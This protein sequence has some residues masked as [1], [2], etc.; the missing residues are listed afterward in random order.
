[1]TDGTLGEGS[2]ASVG[3]V[4]TATEGSGTV[5]AGT[6]GTASVGHGDL[7]SS[8]AGRAAQDALAE[9]RRRLAAR[10]EGCFERLDDAVSELYALHSVTADE[11]LARVQATID[12]EDSRP[13]Q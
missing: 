5:G 9:V 10:R 11:I 7:H 4:G 6:A 13:T 2:V 1:V 12:S 8:A 3:A